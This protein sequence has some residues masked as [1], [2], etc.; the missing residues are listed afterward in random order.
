MEDKIGKIVHPRY[1][2]KERTR[3]LQSMLRT[4]YGTIVYIVSTLLAYSLFRKEYWFPSMVG[5]C[6]ACSEI[7]K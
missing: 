4:S 1:E 3:K 2:G 7:Y 5:G 6:G